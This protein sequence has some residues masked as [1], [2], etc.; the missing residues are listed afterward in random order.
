[1]RFINLKETA[2][3]L[4]ILVIGLVAVAAGRGESYSAVLQKYRTQRTRIANL[5]DKIK[6]AL[7]Q[8]SRIKDAE[9]KELLLQQVRRDHQELK[10]IY[11]EYE[12]LERE[13][14]FRYPEKEDDDPRQ[15]RL[16]RLRSLEQMEQELGLDGQ[17]DSLRAKIRQKYPSPEKAGEAPSKAHP[18]PV[19]EE[20]F[21]LEN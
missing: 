15:Y 11:Q 5:E 19:E 18:Q 3:I 13:I 8:K 16:F 20:V 1:M 10:K 14:R 2:I 6:E 7:T 21:R 12:E 9:Q 4:V 17:L